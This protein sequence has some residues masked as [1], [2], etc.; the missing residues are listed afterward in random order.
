MQNFRD[1]V[2]VPIHAPN[3]S[4]SSEHVTIELDSTGASY[5]FA[6]RTRDDSE[7]WSELSN[8]VSISTESDTISPRAI[9]DLTPGN[10]GNS[11]VMLAW[12]VPLD[13]DN[14]GEFGIISEYEIRHSSQLI[15]SET[16][17]DQATLAAAE[18]VSGERWTLA[19][20]IVK[21]LT[22]NTNYYFAIKT[23]D[24]A[25]NLS[26][27]SNCESISTVSGWIQFRPLSAVPAVGLLE[28][29]QG[30]DRLLAEDLG[31]ITF[32]KQLANGGLELVSTLAFY[33]GITGLVDL[34]QFAYVATNSLGKVELVDFTNTAI[35][36]HQ[37][38]P[39]FGNLGFDDAVVIEGHFLATT[40]LGIIL[41]VYDISDFFNPVKVYPNESTTISDSIFASKIAVVGDFLV[42]YNLEFQSQDLQVLN[43]SNPE[44][45]ER[46]SSFTVPG[47]IRELPE[48]IAKV[49]TNAIAVASTDVLAFYDISESGQPILRSTMSYP[50]IGTVSN[51]AVDSNSTLAFLSEARL[52][53]SGIFHYGLLALDLSD[54]SHPRI[55]SRYEDPGWFYGTAHSSDEFKMYPAGIAVANSMVYVSLN[56][57][58]WEGRL[59]SF[60]L[61][62]DD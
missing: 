34:G 17:W 37:P 30:G 31:G 61:L 35:P 8:V 7:N 25:G 13:L 23:K 22:P 21:D 2:R 18:V 40:A 20:A 16:R 10:P 32:F 9:N 53:G 41:E 1:A 52:D 14:N 4:G 51:L 43:M 45:P 56:G 39:S 38:V 24:G 62:K 60:E 33:G 47:M 58:G 54:L 12:R 36:T 3:S 11:T 44:R 28:L 42:S 57:D 48:W 6:L 59:Q 5:Y 55:V 27:L 26:P 29:H 19:N 46:V 50:E 15:N 49:A